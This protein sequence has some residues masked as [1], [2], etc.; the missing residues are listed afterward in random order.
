MQ[1]YTDCFQHRNTDT[2]NHQHT[3]GNRTGG[4]SHYGSDNKWYYCNMCGYPVV[5]DM[6]KVFEL[7]IYCY[8]VCPECMVYFESIRV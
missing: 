4:L 1:H 3:P 7:D 2:H 6:V 8:H 5:L